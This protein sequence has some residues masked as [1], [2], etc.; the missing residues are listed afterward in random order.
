MSSVWIG[1]SKGRTL[2]SLLCDSGH[3]LPFSA[4]ASS[5]CLDEETLSAHPLEPRQPCDLRAGRQAGCFRLVNF[6]DVGGRRQVGELIR[7]QLSEFMS[8][9][10]DR[11]CPF[12][13]YIA[14]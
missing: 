4:W 6:V 2:E 11:H 3:F 8:K 7:P 1:L 9:E 12:I 14:H 13:E 10:S 5:S